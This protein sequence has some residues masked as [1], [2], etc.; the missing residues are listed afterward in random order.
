MGDLPIMGDLPCLGDLPD[1]RSTLQHERLQ[2]CAVAV[3]HDGHVGR[4]H[5]GS[6]VGVGTGMVLNELAFLQRVAS[7]EA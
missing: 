3:Q 5:H 2:R 1:M 4:H 7:M 6:A